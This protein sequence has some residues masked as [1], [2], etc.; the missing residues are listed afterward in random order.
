MIKK[1]ITYFKKFF[2]ANNY[3]LFKKLFSLFIEN[4]TN[5]F[6]FMFIK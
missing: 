2:F 6:L 3:S 5:G 1:Y 4:L